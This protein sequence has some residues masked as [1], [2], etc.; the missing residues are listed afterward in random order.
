MKSVLFV[1]AGRHQRRAIIQAR[2]RGLRVVAVDRNAER[3]GARR[4]RRRGGRR[5]RRRRRGDGGRAH[6]RRR[7]RAHG[8]GRSRGPGRRRGDR[9]PRAAL[10]RNCGRPAH[11][12]QDRDAALLRRG[13]RAPASVRRGPRSR[14]CPRGAR[15][16]RASC[17]AQAGRL[18]RPACRLPPRERGAPRE[19]APRRPGRVTQQRGDRRG[20]RRRARA[21]RNR[22]CTRRG[23]RGADAVR[24]PSTSRAWVRRR[25]DPRVPRFD[26]RRPA[27]RR[28]SGPPCTRCARLA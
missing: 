11:D 14:E 20:I 27:C 5:L 28:P 22:D 2:E 24:P 10:D 13:G 4:S 12:A 15:D 25:V 16:R 8:L 21:Q 6:A 18:G 17:G 9:A 3:A 1:G 26:L 19:L 7:R 23:D